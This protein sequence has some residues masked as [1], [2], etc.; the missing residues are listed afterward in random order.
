MPKIYITTPAYYPN[1]S[2]HVGHA[3]TTIASDILARWW[4][5]KI[6]NENVMFISGLDEHGEKIEKA[7]EEKG[8]KPQEFVDMMAK[9]FLKTWKVLNISL[10]GFIRTSE[11]RHI[12]IVR[13][14]F[15]KIY[16][17]GDI[18][19]GFYEGWYCVP[20]ESFWT[21]LQLVD[22]CCPECKRPVK[23]VKEESYFFRLSKYQKKLLDLYK[24]NPDFITPASKRNEIV[25]RVREGLDDLSI[26]RLK[27]KW[28]IP[29][30]IDKKSTLYCWIDALSFYISVLDYPGSKFKKFWPPD[31]QLMSKEI[32]WFHSVIFP[33]LLM[34]ARIPLAKK[35]FIHG[36]LTANGEKMSKSKGNF[37]IP[38]DMV[39]KYGVDAFR[40]FLFRQIPFGDD[41]DFSEDALK[42]RINGELLSDLGNLVSRVLTLAEKYK[43]DVKGKPELENKLNLKKIEKLM[44]GLE[45]HHAIYEI[46]EFIRACNK[47][48]NENEPWKQEGKELGNTLYN[49]LEALRII[50]ILT[51]PFIP[52]TAGK[53]DKQLGI[54][55]GMLKDCKFKPFNGKPKKG[56]HLF[57]KIK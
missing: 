46:F 37:I 20:C 9:K 17:A 4:K 47:Y 54:K 31:I 15:K 55:A 44:E 35:V 50:A 13:K 6:G 26:S 23:K 51:S 33:S 16:D 14:M 29:V 52:D 19:K 3:Y 1:L 53:I 5:L 10:D 30:P 56:E 36:W 18:Y 24:K 8:L 11:E 12:E 45:L 42:A 22:G 49:L 28:G 7:A 32:N 21:E 48:I 2:P 27:V 41:G 39:N 57:T 38:E 40:Y 25:N 43:G 34:S